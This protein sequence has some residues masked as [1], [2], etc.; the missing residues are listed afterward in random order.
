MVLR[1]TCI[2][3]LQTLHSPL[4]IILPTPWWSYLYRSSSMGELRNTPLKLKRDG[5]M[6]QVILMYITQIVN[7]ISQI[8]CAW[9]HAMASWQMCQHRADTFVLVFE[10]MNTSGCAGFTSTTGLLWLLVW[11]VFLPLFNPNPWLRTTQVFSGAYHVHTHT[12]ASICAPGTQQQQCSFA[13]TWWC[14][15]AS[16]GLCNSCGQH[17]KGSGMV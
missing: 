12:W 5:Y 15:P 17:A 11:M 2:I 13:A 7:Q 4:S 8:W 9:C 14:L 6:D 16:W 3:I 1:T 10:I